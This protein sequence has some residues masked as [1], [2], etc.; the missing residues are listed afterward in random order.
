MCIS[1]FPYH[2]VQ[3][4]TLFLNSLCFIVRKNI[5]PLQFLC[6]C[7]FCRHQFPPT[8]SR[9]TNQGGIPSWQRVQLQSSATPTSEQKTPQQNGLNPGSS[10]SN[11]STE[12]SPTTT[13]VAASNGVL[14]ASSSIASGMNLENP[15]GVSSH[16]PGQQEAQ[17]K[18]NS[19]E[20]WHDAD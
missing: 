14:S 11:S 8:P 10:A 12:S 9:Q 19:G 5:S 7:F 13:A 18:I 20:E 6:F 4:C 16:A 1:F 15:A 17:I 3:T 2:C